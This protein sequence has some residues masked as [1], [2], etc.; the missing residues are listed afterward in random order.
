MI[1]GR[2]MDFAWGRRYRSMVGPNTAQGNGWDFSY[3]I[4]VV[5]NGPNFDV[6]GGDGRT[7]TYFLQSDGTYGAD[8]LFCVGTLSNNAFTL[9][10]PDTGRWAFLPFNSSASQGKIGSIIDRNGNSLSFAYDDA[11]GRLTNVVDTLGRNIQV[12]Y[13]A[14]GFISS[15]T[16]FAGR[17][18]TYGYYQNGD[19]GGSLGDLKSV[20]SPAVTGTPNGNDFP[21][22]KTVTYTYSTGYADPHLNHK[23]LTIT[24]AQGRDLAGQH[25][26]FDDELGGFQLWPAPEPDAR[27]LERSAQLLLQTPA[28]DRLQWVCGHKGHRQRPG[29]QRVGDLFD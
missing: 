26:R 28:A 21:A 5:P 3:N 15:V 1:K 6:S 17:Q 22:G 24:D 7:D 27:L 19:A 16:D 14:D 10:F 2:G 9:E 23:L 13:N 29:G 20:T 18:V 12:A 11:F 4:Q 25:L 8:Q